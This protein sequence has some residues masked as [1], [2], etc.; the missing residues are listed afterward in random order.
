MSVPPAFDL[1]GLLAEDQWIRRLSRKLAADPH[2]AEDLVQDA[3]VA[4][5]SARDSGS[6]PR[7]LRPW[8]SGVV[9]NLW[10]DW[11]RVGG[12]RTLRERRSARDEALP[13]AGE[14]ASELELRKQ[15][16]AAL[17][18]LEEPYRR[19][20]YLRFFRDLSLRAIAEAEGVSI[21]AVHERLH[22]GLARLRARLARESGKEKGSWAVAL[23]ALARP[24]GPWHATLETLAM[25]IGMKAA[26]AVL[27][28]GGGMVWWWAERAEPER[29]SLAPVPVVAAGPEETEEPAELAG[30]VGPDVQRLALAADPGE[31]PPV[32][33]ETP[34][35]SGAALVHGRVLDVRG[36]PVSEVAVGWDGDAS[37]PGTRAG[38]DGSFAL[39][40]PATSGAGRVECR[41]PDLATLVHGEELGLGRD[42]LTVV[43]A[44]RADF[45]GVVL[46]PDGTPIAGAEVAFRLRDELFREL[47]L[48]RRF[49]GGSAWRTNTDAQGRF[50]LDD[51]AGGERVFLEIAAGGF[52]RCVLELPALGAAD[53]V[54]VLQPNTR[55]LVVRGIVIDA[56]G[57]PVVDA[58]VSAGHEIVRSD[59]AGRFELRTHAGPGPFDAE[60][61]QLA[62]PGPDAQLVALKP[63]FLPAR[64][65]F[66]D[67]DLAAEVVLRLGA[68]P[69]S[70][71]GRVLDAVGQPRAGIVVWA[72]DPTPFGRDIQSV[73]EGTT[74]A[75]EKTVEDE[76]AGGFGQRGARTDA[77]GAFELGGLIE[78]AYSLR[79][80][81][82][83]TADFGGPWTIAAGRRDAELVLTSE[84]ER[85]PV[86]GRLVST[87]GRPLAGVTV[88]AQRKLDW[89]SAHAQPPY[90]GR[91]EV[92]TDAEGR[93]AFEELA[94]AGTELLLESQPFFMR[95]VALADHPDPAHLELVEPLLCELQVELSGDPG[96]ADSLKVL[97]AAEHELETIESF[98]N[99]WSLG[100]EAG[101]TDGLSPVV[102][103]KETAT[104]LVLSKKGVEVLRR[105]LALDP[106][107][108]TVVR[109]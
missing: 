109:P 67:L 94:L 28:L 92:E 70:I 44:P 45:A 71:A 96:F 30:A 86:A 31:P 23:L 43:V 36:A 89:T 54:A 68:A 78:R 99:G 35:A 20:L 72:V 16:A 40:R 91:H 24:D 97:D 80:F 8:L 13:S 58:Q 104:T 101:I 63:G 3:W 64:E 65:R 90:H 11:K 2:Q 108:R 15:V 39:A 82:P 34:P 32:R 6:R 25:G 61:N 48:Q 10:I 105:P 51:L 84:A 41:E 100:T 14:L 7:A 17:L 62:S 56:H 95:T 98:G 88:S 93:F 50:A 106:D 26:V 19:A 9:R 21:T 38:L 18:E 103:V 83:R 1:S 69:A 53:L 59:A 42:D 77:H 29:V 74:F 57:A 5:L 22:R 52:L 27:A 81:D 85:G 37:A 107:E 49:D 87:R 102:T 33:T 60:G 66:A 12:Q 73:A 47:G 79:A 75:W 76:L 55:G 4:A 46:A